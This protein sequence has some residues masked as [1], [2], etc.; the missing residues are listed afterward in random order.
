M[1]PAVAVAE[2]T[3]NENK[4]LFHTIRYIGTIVG[5]SVV[6]HGVC[7]VTAVPAELK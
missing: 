4:S 7:V 2:V 5:K 6:V 3:V 1:S